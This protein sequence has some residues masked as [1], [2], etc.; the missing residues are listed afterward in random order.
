MPKFVP[1]AEAEAAIARAGGAGP[2]PTT[3]SAAAPQPARETQVCPS[4]CASECAQP[5]LSSIAFSSNAPG[6]VSTLA[7][8]IISKY[9]DALPRL[10]LSM[11][12]R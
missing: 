11:H 7:A 8:R 5:P 10:L 9:T 12:D 6:H 2:A 3:A 1:V 4:F